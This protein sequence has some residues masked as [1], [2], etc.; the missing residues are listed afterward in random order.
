MISKFALTN[1]LSIIGITVVLILTPLIPFK[2]FLPIGIV[3]IFCIHQ[4]LYICGMFVPSSNFFM[5]SIK[6]KEFFGGNKGI[7]FRFDDGPDPVY[8]PRILEI[9][10]SE[11]INALF[12]V[13][14]KNAELY[15]EL[16]QQIQK[17]G[18]IIAN[19]TYSHPFN[20]VLLGYRQISKEITRTN[21]IIQDVTG[22][23][24]RYFCSPMGHKS[25]I[26]GKVISDL[27][28]IPVMWDVR[29]FDTHDTQEKI[30]NRIKKRVK[31][32]AII[33]FH[34]GIMPWS[35]K[36]RESTILALQKTIPMLREKSYI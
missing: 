28:L 23:K 3:L 20:I 15:P 34:D 24:P 36:D 13:T 1:I 30:I 7:L 32:P 33:T 9:L 5:K 19:H 11:E 17:E 16:V 18:H 6:G 8:T 4:T 27:G 21:Q 10:K 12:A 22:E 31:S 35:Q 14:G 29:T 25:P 26:L 2:L